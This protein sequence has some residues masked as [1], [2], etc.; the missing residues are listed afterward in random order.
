MEKQAT[1]NATNATATN[2]LT[3]E[4]LEALGL[5]QEIYDTLP[6]AAKNI[7]VNAEIGYMTVKLEKRK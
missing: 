7:I 1:T 4:Q 6:E 3:A 2:A 5:T